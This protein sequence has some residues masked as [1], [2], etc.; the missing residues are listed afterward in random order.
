MK[1]QV[2][3][4]VVDDEDGIRSALSDELTAKGYAVDEASDG[5][6]AIACISKKAFDLVLLD[7]KMT[8]VDGLEVLKF[9]KKEF[10]TMKVIMTTGSADPNVVRELKDL[11]ADNYMSKPYDL[12]DLMLTI[13]EVLNR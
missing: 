12:D 9:I 6:E 13:E 1:T 8:R 11:G 5:D 7:L 3:I 10:P 2:R 4:L